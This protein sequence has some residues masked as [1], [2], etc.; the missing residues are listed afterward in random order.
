MAFAV[1][2]FRLLLTALGLGLVPA[3]WSGR[4]AQSQ[5]IPPTQHELTLDSL[6]SA[7]AFQ[8]LVD[9]ASNYLADAVAKN[10]TVMMGR[11]LTALGRGEI[12]LGRPGGLDK[13]EQ[14][15]QV[16]RAVRDT[17]NWMAALGY[18]SL[19]LSY[20]GRFDES[21]ELNE[22]RL[23]LARLAGDQAS[24]AWARTM[25]AYIALLRGDFESARVEY[26]AAVDLF[27][28]MGLE[29]EVLTPLLGLGR[30]YNSL[31]EVDNA[32]K[33]YQRVLETAREVGD[34]VNEAHAINN[35]GTI[36]YEYGDMELAVQYY[37]RS[38][39][40]AAESGNLRGTVTPGT[41]IAM[42]MQ[43]LGRYAD[44]DSTLTSVLEMCEREG[45]DE[46]IPMILTG[47]GENRFL[48]GRYNASVT[49]YRRLLDM[50]LALPKKEHDEAVYGL[51][52]S[53]TYLGEAQ[54]AL[55]VLNTSFEV[56]P[57]PTLAGEIHWSK[58][59]CLLAL[60]R[61]EEALEEALAAEEIMTSSGSEH[62]MVATALRLS[63]CYCGLGRIDEAM[64]WFD[65]SVRR[66]SARQSSKKDPVWRE[67]FGGTENLVDAS[68][69]ILEQSGKPRGVR[70]AELF[71]LIQK[72][73]VR[74]LIERI[75]EPRRR[76]EPAP[77]IAGI[78]LVDLHALQTDVL[79]PGELFLD[80]AVGEDAGYLFAVSRDSCRVVEIPGTRS[81]LAKRV[82]VY[83]AFLGRRPEGNGGA[84]ADLTGMNAS[85]GSAILGGVAD[86][87]RSSATLI[88]SP[89]SFYTGIP[90]GELSLSGDSG[91]GGSLIS[92][93]VI[94]RVP[95]ATI[96]AWLRSQDGKKAA[97]SPAPAILVVRPAGKNALAGARREVEDLEQRY[98]GV[99]EARGTNHGAS[100]AAN[101][102]YDV[103]H[104]AAHTEVND[105]KPWHSGILMG[106]AK[107]DSE[108]HADPFLR[109]GDIAAQRMPAR[110]A[111]LS[112][113]ESAMGRPSVGEGVAGLTAAF[114]SA[115]VNAVVATLWRVDDA[116][117]ADL[118]ERF[119]GRLADG[120]PA[121]A[122]L[123]AAQ[124]ETQSH[125][126]TRHPFYWAG[127]V[128]V[129]DG[130]VTVE[131]QRRPWKAPTSLLLILLGIAAVSA[132]IGI[133]FRFKK[134]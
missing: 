111:V 73:K 28:E 29:R 89:T 32:R 60:D 16:S 127:F 107:G 14:S 45:F 66:F 62:R 64:K 10:D 79:E 43:Y 134:L 81:A 105:E 120:L 98:R 100:L 112:G 117:T 92:A 77:G 3:L 38:R 54:E 87:V 70:E 110:L 126:E 129:G 53:L 12:M 57:I 59:G 48:Q 83:R 133:A 90:Y 25:L 30:V 21:R 55:D 119:Y 51:A 9:L 56:A 41:N 106:E 130:G 88:V 13:L 34:R 104:V 39:Q 37:E 101:G 94:Q 114:L 118:M 58:A 72:F 96:L 18:K 42:A 31:Q 109:A 75:T 40:M 76:D 17:T 86:L 116:V 124:I 50:G 65:E 95:S 46:F 52:R 67:S 61:R 115:G 44:A 20:Q 113:C 82:A 1:P 80:F 33:C 108:F 22:S 84:A 6:F 128:V 15:I 85:M 7:G 97:G 103:I 121:A 36:E 93:K 132:A 5:P 131:L 69:V 8:P 2:R 35:L 11:M 63:R 122:A 68:G 71:D 102:H 49:G 4:V 91:E 78:D 74:T 23:R 24:E 27:F 99:R 47:L 26:A 123:R 125:G 19:V